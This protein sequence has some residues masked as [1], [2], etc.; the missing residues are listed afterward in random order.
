MTLNYINADSGKHEKTPNYIKNSN[1]D[2]K[3]K[4]NN[5]KMIKARLRISINNHIYGTRAIH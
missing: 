5:P 3:L 2:N 4:D 1:H